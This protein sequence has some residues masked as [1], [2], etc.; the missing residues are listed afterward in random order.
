MSEF[1]T[2][3]SNVNTEATYTAAISTAAIHQGSQAHIDVINARIAARKAKSKMRIVQQIE[4]H[5]NNVDNDNTDII[6]TALLFDISEL[7]NSELADLDAVMQG[8]GYSCTLNGTICTI[9]KQ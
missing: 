6:N 7:T 9:D 1:T 2:F 5:F 4:D 3:L 8:K